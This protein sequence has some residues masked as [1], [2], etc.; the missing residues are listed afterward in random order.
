MSQE[1]ITNYIQDG[2]KQGHLVK[3]I[4]VELTLVVV[5]FP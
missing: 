1:T 5:H 2:V 4:L 3:A